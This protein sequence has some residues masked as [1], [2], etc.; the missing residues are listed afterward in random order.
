MAAPQPG[1]TASARRKQGKFFYLFLVQ[2]LLI[3]LFPYLN[4]PGLPTALFRLLGAVAFLAAV[5]AVSEK[6]VQWII[7]LFLAVPSA[8]L[9]VLFTLRPDLPIA[10]PGM[11]FTIL[12]LAFTLFTLLRAVLRAEAVTPD[13]I[14]G[15]LS[16][17]LLMAFLWGVAYLLVE[18]LH[19]G[20]LSMDN[21][22]HPNHNADWFDCMFYSFV[23]LTSLGYGDMV[24]VTA[25]SRSL[26]ILEAVS[27]IMYIGVLV[28]RLV[29]LYATQPP[30]RT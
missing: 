2:V 28:A 21:V 15:A 22:R 26:S 10:V 18:N 4:K 25:Q 24:P 1:L 5:Y 23:T 27:G 14:Y 12:F 8:V 16:V 3:A 29:G 6:R 20:A 13:T 30:N 9:N 7:A 11:I 19:P 17:Y